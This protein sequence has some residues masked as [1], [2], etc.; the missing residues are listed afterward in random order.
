MATLH[1]DTDAVRALSA[2][3]KKNINFFT[4]NLISINKLVNIV[5]GNSW[6]GGSSTEFQ[7]TI[8]NWSQR[9]KNSIEE[10]SEILH[11]LEVEISQW[12]TMS[13]KMG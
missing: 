11:R 1:M 6:V 3:I 7:L 4:E 5:V 12:E 13:Q 10:L 8:E 2:E 9:E